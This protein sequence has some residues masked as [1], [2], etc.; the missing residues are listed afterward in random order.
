MKRVIAI[1]MAAVLALSMVACGGQSELPKSEITQITTA[2][3]EEK[4]TVSLGR[5]E[6]GVY[7]NKYAGFVCTLDTDWTF[8]TAEELQELP[9]ETAKLFEGSELDASK[10]ETATITD[11][12]AENVMDLCSINVQYQKLSTA[13]RI[14]FKM[15]TEEE[16][17]DE[18]LKTKDTMVSAYTSAGIEVA[19]MEKK[20]VQFMG[21][22]RTVIYTAASIQGVPLYILQI[23]DY[24]KGSFGV[25]IT[26]GTYLEDN[27]ESLL[28]LFTPV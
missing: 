4:D 1:L 26:L 14:A 21:Q 3:A 13:E 22:E 19:S 27:T 6:G 10:I 16:V 25:I 28:S 7:T 11:M 5:M 9:G 20:T 18:L 8:L 17:I 15:A 2:P 23:M 12:M 24:T